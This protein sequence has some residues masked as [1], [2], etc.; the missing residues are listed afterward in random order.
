MTSFSKNDTLWA[1]FTGLFE[2]SFSYLF[3]VS[4]LVNT[5]YP[6]ALLFAQEVYFL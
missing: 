2:A 6:T 4:D 5:F 1:Y 3:F